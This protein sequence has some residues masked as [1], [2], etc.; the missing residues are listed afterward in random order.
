VKYKK[1]I[2]PMSN[3]LKTAKAATLVTTLGL[4]LAIGVTSCGQKEATEAPKTEAP[5]TEAPKT[6]ASAPASPSAEAVALS[7]ADKA[8]VTPAKVA[9]VAANTAVKG[10]DMA[11]AKAQFEKFSG[12]WTTVEPILKAKAGSNYP[13]IETGINMVKANLIDAK[14]P[15][16]AKVS[17]GLTTAIKA[18]DT[19][20]NKK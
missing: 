20:L 13:L 11:K 9:L 8:V 12:V 15:D 7:P 6:E 5:K 1:D 19:V 16:K 18:I 17:E 2:H 10:G 3:N 4:M 14:T